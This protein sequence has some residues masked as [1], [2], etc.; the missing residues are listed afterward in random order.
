MI[1]VTYLLLPRVPL[2]DGLIFNLKKN[3]RNKT[4][5]IIVPAIEV[6]NI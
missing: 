6:N 2:C 5:T 3:S 4:K 1:D